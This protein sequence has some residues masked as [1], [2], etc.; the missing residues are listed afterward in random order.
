MLLAEVRNSNGKSS[1]LFSRRATVRPLNPVAESHVDESDVGPERLGGAFHPRAVG[2]GADLETGAGQG[3]REHL[4]VRG[5]SST[6][7]TRSPASVV[8]VV[9]GGASSG[10]LKPSLKEP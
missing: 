10:P 8:T 3:G 6:R 7:S 1:A 2:L 9:M 4:R 5:S